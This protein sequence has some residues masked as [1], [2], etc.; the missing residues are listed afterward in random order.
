MRRAPWRARKSARALARALRILRRKK[1]KE[2]ERKERK[3]RKKKG[4][5]TCFLLSFQRV[6]FFSLFP[7]FSLVFSLFSLSSYAAESAE[8]VEERGSS[9]TGEGERGRPMKLCARGRGSS[10]SLFSLFVSGSASPAS[11]SPSRMLL[12]RG[13][14]EREAFH[15]RTS[16]SSVACRRCSASAMLCTCFFPHTGTHTRI[17]SSLPACE[18]KETG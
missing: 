14:G 5:T 2:K 1:E 6:G 10:V 13:R 18:R 11:L 7:F 12:L 8:K 4:K 3:R 17:V 16:P 15:M 9:S